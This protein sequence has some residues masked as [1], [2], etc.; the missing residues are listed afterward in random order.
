MKTRQATFAGQFYPENKD[1]LIALIKEIEAEE[2]PKIAFSNTLHPIIGGV[3]PHAGYEFSGYE[4][5]HFFKILQKSRQVFDTVV[6][7]NPDHYGMRKA[8]SIDNHTKWD[9]PLGDVKIDHK[10]A[11]ATELPREPAANGEHSA[12]VMLPFLKYYL[13]Y[14]FKILPVTITKQD[15]ITASE[16]ASALW[17]AKNLTGK[18]IV[19]IASCDFSHFTEPEQG[20]RRDDLIIE[21]IHRLDSK[22]IYEKVS[23]YNLTICGYGPIMTLI[24]YSK[25]TSNYPEVDILARGNSA[26][27]YPSQN[28]VNYV[29]IIF[30]HN[31]DEKHSF[32]SL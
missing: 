3:V 12:E 1:E 10:F 6:I 7:L 17:E 20:K 13:D 23:D 31:Y 21:Q 26:K 28:V 32:R 27:K 11:E 2:R 29:S 14:E 8:I 15:F 22:A 9:S 19:L 16:T 4:A 30:N 25:L 18:N 5:I 24:E